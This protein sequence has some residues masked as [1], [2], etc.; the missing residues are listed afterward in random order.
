VL[1]AALSTGAAGAPGHR[2][3]RGEGENEEG[4]E[5][6][7]RSCLPRLENDS[8]DSSAWLRVGRRRFKATAVLR[9]PAVDG[10]GWSSDNLAS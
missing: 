5:G 1:L 3:L 7:I 6:V 2:G 8:G 9:W 4:G 10:K